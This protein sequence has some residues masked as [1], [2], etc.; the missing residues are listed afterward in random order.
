MES[1]ESPVLADV[2]V[3]LIASSGANDVVF[4]TEA[5]NL[6]TA[7]AILREHTIV[8]DD[9]GH[10]AKTPTLSL[11]FRSRL[12]GGRPLEDH[13]GDVLNQLHM[14]D[15][16][17][18]GKFFRIYHPTM[19][20]RVVAHKTTVPSIAFSREILREL[21]DISCEL[22]IDVAVTELNDRESSTR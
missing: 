3:M 10:P 2:S 4:R 13:V 14:G 6:V 17:K 9:D 5:E 22:D 19:S 12:H 1:A 8:V 18:Q 11:R 20:V 15:T 16:K 21:A 7:D